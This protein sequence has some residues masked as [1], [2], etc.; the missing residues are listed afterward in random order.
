[1]ATR[2]SAR[3]APASESASEANE[4]E[5]RDTVRYSV[6]LRTETHEALKLFCLETDQKM[7]PLVLAAMVADMASPRLPN[8]SDI[9]DW[10]GEHFGYFHEHGSRADT[11][12]ERLPVLMTRKQRQDFSVHCFKLGKT[13]GSERAEFLILQ[14]LHENKR[15]TH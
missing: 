4:S 7:G 13:P 2:K 10:I 15:T 11:H 6:D 3:V 9:K 12:T 8:R 5:K 1:M 14:L